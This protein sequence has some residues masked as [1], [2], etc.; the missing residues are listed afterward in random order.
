MPEDRQE[1]SGM[2]K[3]NAGSPVVWLTLE[4]VLEGVGKYMLR[5][6]QLLLILIILS[7]RGGVGL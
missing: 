6:L 1:I 3:D 7:A 2:A 5:L 4:K